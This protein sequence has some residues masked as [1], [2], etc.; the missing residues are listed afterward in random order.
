[1]LEVHE[2]GDVTETI[3]ID[4]CSLSG[5]CSGILFESQMRHRIQ[6]QH[7]S[8]L[9]GVFLFLS[10]INLFA[11]ESSGSEKAL[12][13]L[14]SH[15]VECHGGKSTRNSLDL[16][17]RENLLKGG[18]A[19]PAIVSG[20]AAESLLIRKVSHSDEPGMPYK[21][22]K[23]P[24]ADIFLL[25][26][27]I[28]SG[29]P[30]DRPLNKGVQE[31][32][33]TW[34]SL[35][36]L[37]KPQVPNTSERKYMNWAR[38]PI[39]HFVLA[40]LQEKGFQPSE[41]ADKRTLL[42]RV[43]FDLVG[44]PPT[45][46]EVDAFLKD[47]SPDAY[48]MIVD[49]LLASPR[50]GER[51]ARH[52]LDIAHY[53]D[54]HG[55][56]QDRPRPN[57]WPYRDYLVRSFNEDKP[58]GRFVQEQ[59]AGDVLFPEEGQGVVATGFIAAGPW[60]ESSQVFIVE[61]T[62]DKK[63]AR[64][65]DRDDM[66]MTTMST[67]TSSTV[68][69]ARCHNHKFD[70]ISQK[71]YYNLQAVF[72]GVDRADRPFDPDLKTHVLR[73]TLLAQKRAL[74]ERSSPPSAAELTATEERLQK[75]FDEDARIWT[76]LDP[77]TFTSSEEATLTKQSDLSLFASG[78]LPDKDIYTITANTDLRGISAVQVEVMADERLPH[79]GPGRQPENGNITLSEFVLKS[80]PK[81]NPAALKVIAL[82]SP[83]ADF[84]QQDWSVEKAIDNN[85]ST[86]WGIHPEEGQSHFAV[87]ETKENV[88]EEGGTTLTF[89]LEQ[90]LG[91]QHVIGRVR[92]SATTAPR[93]VRADRLPLN[94]VKILRI[95]RGQ[96]TEQQRKDLITFY[97]RYEI[98]QQ[99]AALPV[100][101]MVYAAANDFVPQGNFTP[102][103]IPRPIHLLR[104]GD[105]TKP[106]DL[107]APG[108]LSCLP[109]M[110]ATLAVSDENSEGLRRAA[111][112]KWIT[113]SKNV[114]TWR[115]I[116]NRVWH[117]HFGRG[118]VDSPNDFGRMGST[119]T[120]PELLDWLAVTFME[121]GGSLKQLHKLILTS[122]VYLQSSKD[123]PAFSKTDSGN[124][125][126]WRMNQ[127]RLDAESIRDGVLQISG[128]L[129]L[130]MAGPSVMQ[131]KFDDPTPARTPTVDY[132]AYDVDSPG[133]YRRSIYRYIFRTMPDPFMDSLDCADA[134]QLTAARN[135]S[136]TALQAMALMNNHFIVRQ[137]EHLAA[138]M[139]V[140]E[141]KGLAKQIER[142]CH[143][144]WNRAPTRTELKTLRNYAANHGL[145]NA[146]RIILNS[147]EFAF[148]N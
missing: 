147:N 55:N 63:I 14:E 145:A 22:E 128:K 28:D 77:S 97:Q 124:L 70:P 80:G 13:L 139:E 64:N 17:S 123:N 24:E 106:A 65:L 43:Y 27:W 9:L 5:S 1:M 93:P 71:E 146:C 47:K 119:P 121:S 44:L 127:N 7:I 42:R 115:S 138:R 131:F 87:F 39:D 101:Q 69:C 114:L 134:S 99:L 110:S 18:D 100:P 82:Q 54:T 120:H 36:P 141:K 31:E 59:I 111:L 38:T 48:T 58:Y 35:K 125:Y 33:E 129:D 6:F 112:A 109:G 92:I 30:F 81:T 148:V 75:I 16:S 3:T 19:G 72:A 76:V 4:R 34:W 56:D 116:V 11:A 46:E 51:W 90:V 41:P 53:A 117:Y 15:C 126:L 136:M 45:P 104:R 84:S 102:T 94:V 135:V 132:V 107:V 25:S 68:H 130:T 78:K 105:I 103:K 29:A 89:V 66:V 21:K 49:R 96:R 26:K 23:L 95:P 10:S 85:P 40:K 144:A 60:D 122:S 86:G 113:D 88:G 32:T 37:L 8:R 137:S 74:V 20:K 2:G 142:A 140:E 61:D 108:A 79:K 91:R 83:T 133:S 143:L 98:D 52:W 12:R 118:I 62:V 50:Y 73:Q 57:A 67:F